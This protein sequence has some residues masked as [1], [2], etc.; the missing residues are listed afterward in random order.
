MVGACP[1]APNKADHD[2]FYSFRRL[3]RTQEDDLGSAGRCGSEGRCSARLRTR[4]IRCPARAGSCR[5]MTAFATKAGPCGYVQRQLT[6]LGH[7]C[8]VVA[9]GAAP[10]QGRRQ[11]EDRPA[12]RDDAGADAARRAADVL[13]AG[14]STRGDAGPGAVAGAG[15]AGFA[16]D[17]PATAELPAAPWLEFAVRPLDEVHRRWQ[18]RR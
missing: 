18:A 12:R 3:G 4:R 10:A 1:Q 5:R 13:G 8:D 17:A 11:G 6:R 2:G 16:Q 7:R 15:D 9:P 14:R